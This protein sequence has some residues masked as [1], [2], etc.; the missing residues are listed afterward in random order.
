MR[1]LMQGLRLMRDEKVVMQLLMAVQKL[2]FMTD[3]AQF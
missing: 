1:V 3:P 2:M